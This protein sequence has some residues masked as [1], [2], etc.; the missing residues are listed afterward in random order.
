MPNISV[1]SAAAIARG[2]TTGPDGEAITPYDGPDE[3]GPLVKWL[4]E[5]GIE[6]IDESGDRLTITKAVVVK[7]PPGED[8]AEPET[9]DPDE[10]KRLRRLAAEASASKGAAQAGITK[11]HARTGDSPMRT[12]GEYVRAMQHKAYNQK[13]ARGE[14]VFPD[15]ELAEVF[16]AFMRRDVVT[17]GRHDYAVKSWD[18]GILRKTNVTTDSS[19]GGALVPDVLQGPMIDIRL[20]YGVAPRIAGFQP[21]SQDNVKL[22]RSAGELTVYYPGEAGTLTESNPRYNNPS[23]V[24][25][26]AGIRTS[27]SNELL[28]DASVNVADDVARKISWAF[29]R[30]LDNRYFAGDGTSAYAGDVGVPARLLGLSGT[31]GNIAGLFVGTGNLWS[32]LVLSDFINTV[33]LLPDL[34]NPAGDPSWVVSKTFWEQVMKRVALGTSGTASTE[35]VGGIRTKTFLGYSVETANAM[36]RVEGNSQVCALFGWFDLGSRVGEVTGSMRLDTDT[37]VGFWEDEIGIRGL[38]RN[39]VTVHDVGNASASASER[40]AGPI[41]GLITAAS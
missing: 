10:L 25:R 29:A 34:E 8:D 18:D 38:V 41:V 15:A 21:M 1:K 32:E 7:S 23:L 2:Q 20:A 17:K 35:V 5:N 22:I 31:I 19:L 14:T 24:A 36:P 33:G 6:L 3:Y 30:D 16:G 12:A 26:K 13:A 27:V 40:Q 28:N 11:A 9:I 37:S 39:A 4:D